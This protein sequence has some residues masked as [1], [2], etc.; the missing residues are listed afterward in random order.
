MPKSPALFRQRL[1]GGKSRGAGLWLPAG[2]LL[3]GGLTVTAFLRL[4]PSGPGISPLVSHVASRYVQRGA[5]ETGQSYPVSAVF[6]DYRSFDLV[7]LALIFLTVSFSL[8]G[9]APRGKKSQLDG[10]LP[11]S[12]AGPLG[13]WGL[14]FFCL[15]AG[16]RFL[17]YEALPLPLLPSQIRPAGAFLLAAGLLLSAVLLVYFALRREERES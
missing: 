4:A 16:S 14:G 6:S 13:V 7:L 11:G 10:R 17:D 2:L 5:L 9:G 1:S 3:A 12:L 15:L 8:F